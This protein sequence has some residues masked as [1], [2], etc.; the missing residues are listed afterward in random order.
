MV[1]ASRNQPMA[2]KPEVRIRIVPKHAAIFQI[3]FL[4][5]RSSILRLSLSQSR[6][7]ALRGIR[8]DT[9]FLRNSTVL[10]QARSAAFLS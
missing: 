8:Q 3:R 2:G 6:C 9:Y 4:R 7:A 1:S 10:P 5:F